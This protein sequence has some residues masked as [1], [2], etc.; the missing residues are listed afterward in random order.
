[1]L[2]AIGDNGLFS[3]GTLKLEIILGLSMISK[4][5]NFLKSHNIIM[6]ISFMYVFEFNYFIYGTVL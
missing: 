6:T 4:E 1:M 5:L 2:A 3:M